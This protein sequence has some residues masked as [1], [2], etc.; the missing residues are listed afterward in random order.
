MC[1]RTCTL[2]PPHRCVYALMHACMLG[3]TGKRVK[4]ETWKVEKFGYL[5]PTT[6]SLPPAPGHT[7]TILLATTTL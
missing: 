7:F 2:L 4:I 3:D 5:V 6:N 1:V